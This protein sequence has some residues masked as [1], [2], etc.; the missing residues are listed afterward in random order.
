MVRGLVLRRGSRHWDPAT[1]GTQ[2]HQHHNA[3]PHDACSFRDARPD[4]RVECP[5]AEG[6]VS[7]AATVV[8]AFMHVPSKTRS[9]DEWVQQIGSF[10]QLNASV[11]MYIDVA[12]GHV[13]A[14]MPTNN[15]IVTV[16]TSM[17]NF[18]STSCGMGVWKQQHSMD[19]PEQT[20][21]PPLVGAADQSLDHLL[22]K[23]TQ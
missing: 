23:Q 3:Q 15:R 17:G 21:S 5:K 10:M 2:P 6:T 14:E 22:R 19:C 4:Y 12:Y 8:T 7:A 1:L 20:N 11:V 9:M 18:K 13:F 16:H